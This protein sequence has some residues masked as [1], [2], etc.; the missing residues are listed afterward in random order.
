ME[1]S[2]G[3][4]QTGS[5]PSPVQVVVETPRGSRNKYK[6]DERSAF[7]A[8]WT[9]ATSTFLDMQQVGFC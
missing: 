9:I 3:R 2:S 5:K 8:Q 7:C 6:F 4:V 1:R